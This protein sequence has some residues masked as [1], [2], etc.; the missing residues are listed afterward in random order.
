MAVVQRRRRLLTLHAAL[1]DTPPWT[2][3][4]IAGL[5]FGVRL[6]LVESLDSYPCALLTS[7]MG[8]LRRR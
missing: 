5:A 7:L 8:A 1:T 2:L 4:Q 3:D 6:L